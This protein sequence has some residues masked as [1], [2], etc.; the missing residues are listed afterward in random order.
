MLT[1]FLAYVLIICYFVIERKLRKGKQALNLQPGS[2]DRGSSRLMWVSGIL[3]ILVILLAPIFNT[4]HIGNWHNVY[5]GWIGLLVMISGLLLR[6]W[7]ARTLGEFYTRTLL[8]TENHQIVTQAPYNI[9][10]HPGYLGV[11]TMS[12]GA[13]L[14]IANW[15]VMLITAIIGFVTYTY[16]IHAEEAMLAATFGKPYQAYINNTWRLIPYIY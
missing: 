5:I 8:I 3:N 6:A 10:R 4:Y 14:A 13:G 2:S 11:F 12:L 1:T 9:I 16:R 15:I 7:A